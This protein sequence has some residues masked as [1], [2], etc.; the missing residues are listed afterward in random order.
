[1][2]VY[3]GHAVDILWYKIDFDASYR[4]TWAQGSFHTWKCLMAGFMDPIWCPVYFDVLVGFLPHLRFQ[5]RC[6][7]FHLCGTSSGDWGPQKKRGVER[8]PEYVLR[9][10]SIY[11]SWCFI[12]DFPWSS[13]PPPKTHKEKQ[14]SDYQQICS[15]LSGCLIMFVKNPR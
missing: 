12:R 14:I 13:Q 5:H 7:H 4:Y 1:M 11:V 8:D 9:L 3:H 6:W 2:H 15:S 10:L